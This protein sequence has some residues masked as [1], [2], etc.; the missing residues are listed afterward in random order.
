MY[1]ISI[2]IP[3]Y[4]TE[5]YIGACLDSIF[6]QECEMAKIECILVNDCTPEKAWRL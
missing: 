3:I 4:K 1:K 5:A 2:I 6:E